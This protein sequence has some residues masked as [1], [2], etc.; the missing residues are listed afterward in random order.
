M[1]KRSLT[2]PILTLGPPPGS[3]GCASP[4]P[5]QA[6][7]A[8]GGLA[9]LLD[10]RSPEGFR[11]IFGELLTR[12]VALDTAILKIRLGAVDLSSHELSGLQRIR[13]LVAELSARTLEEEAYALV[14]DREKRD[15]LER[16]LELL[17]RGSLEIRS[18]PLGGWSPDFSVFSGDHHPHSVLIG[19]HWFQRPFPHR[20][21]AWAAR[22]GAREAR[23]AAGR[24]AGIWAGAHDIGPA[25]RRLLERAAQRREPHAGVG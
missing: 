24:F 22:F 17:R 2:S 12:S 9:E 5:P 25:V 1:G 14:V 16:I 19:L 13:V 21:P 4:L 10:E 11:H 7:A 15:N 20:G 23:W 8:S 18:A 3:G 6:D